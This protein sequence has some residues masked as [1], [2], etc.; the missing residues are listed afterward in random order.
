MIGKLLRGLVAIVVYLCIATM[1][2]EGVLVAWYA[3][4]WQVDRGKLLH[5]LA[6]AQ[7]VNLDAIKEQGQDERPAASTEQPSYEQVLESRAA[8]T[9][10]LELREQAL[11]DNLQRLQS[12]QRKLADEY[13]R[14]QQLREGFQGDLL[15]ERKKA[16]ATGNEDVLRTLETLKPKQAKEQLALMLEKKELDEVVRLM[17]GMADGKRAKI[18]AE[19]KTPGEVEQI[20]EI[21]R[22]I[23]QGLPNAAV[24]ENA[25]KRLET[26]KG[27]GGP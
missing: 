2:A 16:A 4:A 18:I 27:P 12:E 8:K 1:I 24:A 9:R 11:R 5:M 10:N 19:F 3:R 26:P 17:S 7:G 14:L 15:A 25:Q 13:K 21:L 20:G 23:R 6:A 22:R